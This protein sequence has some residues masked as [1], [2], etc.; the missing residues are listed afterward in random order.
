MVSTSWG[1]RV[2]TSLGLLSLDFGGD[3]PM[4]LPWDQALP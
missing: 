3:G 2:L 4:G 1:R